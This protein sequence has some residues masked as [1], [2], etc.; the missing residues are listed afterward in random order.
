MLNGEALEVNSVTML[1][2]VQDEKFDAKAIVIELNLTVIKQEAWKT[3]LLNEGDKIEVISF[4]G[5]G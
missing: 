1:E 5:G 2:L 4:V 3:T